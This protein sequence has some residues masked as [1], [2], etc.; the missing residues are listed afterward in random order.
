MEKMLNQIIIT[1][2]RLLT[3]PSSPPYDKEGPHYFSPHFNYTNILL[4]EIF[5]IYKHFLTTNT[6]HLYIW[7]V[8]IYS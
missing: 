5:Y 6:L 7:H 4:L 1:I 2:P 3:E 8:Y